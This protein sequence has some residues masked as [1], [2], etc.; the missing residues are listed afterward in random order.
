MNSPATHRG[1]I[2]LI[3]GAVWIAGLFVA[4]PLVGEFGPAGIAQVI[5]LR[6]PGWLS[7]LAISHFGF[8]AIPAL[9]IGVV[10]G[11]LAISALAS[12]L[13]FRVGPG[14]AWMAVG[15]GIVGTA[16]VFHVAGASPSAGFALGIVVALVPPWIAGRLLLSNWVGT[17]R[18]RFLRRTGGIVVGGVVTLGGLRFVIDRLM[19][20]PVSP[21]VLE[22]LA[23][24]VSPPQGD[25]SFDFAGM[26]SAVTP[27]GEHYVVDINVNPPRIDPEWWSLEIDGEVEQPYALSYD[28]LLDHEARI[29][30]TTT[31]ICISNRLGGE[32]I[33]TAHWTGI[34]LSDLIA[35]AEP[36]DAAVDVVTYADDG[37]SEAI[38][39]ELIERED[40][41]IAYGM[42]DRT[43]ATEHGFPA[44]L[45][46]PGRY[47]MKMTKWITRIEV[48]GASHEAYWQARGWNEEAIVNTMSYI[49]GVERN[50]EEV[51]VGG[52]AFAGLETGVKEIAGVEVSLDDGDTWHDAEVEDQLAAHAWRRWK[53]S[54]EAGE[55]TTVDVVSRAIKMDGSVQTGE[56]SSP[57]PN[58][59]TGWHRRQ[60]TI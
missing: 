59:A 25:P 60:I 35:A 15:A 48:A 7:T 1:A 22:P 27:R 47:G 37:Y 17:D 42:G 43:L 38:P 51:T 5:I 2:G 21:R 11:I 29:E 55:Q 34:Q 33:G 57:R 14:P 18:R 40:I 45:L 56:V 54:F 31:M 13:W 12:I 26:P 41:L 9:V 39:I 24:P 36:T 32:L 10:V 52:V 20:P 49:R 3:V 16:A 23:D 58:G 4:A 44:R 46:I 19:G 6:S 30:Q 53:Y 8:F 28:E 50:G